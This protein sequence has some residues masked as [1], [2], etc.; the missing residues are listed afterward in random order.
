MMLMG[1][2]LLAQAVA[3]PAAV[4]AQAP[5]PPSDQEKLICHSELV[6]ASRIAQRICRTKA[7]WDRIERQSEDE[8]RTSMNK[9]NNP[10]NSPE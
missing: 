8:F 3:A 1:L 10:G 7:E 9:Q 2:L 6:G 5:A 4:S